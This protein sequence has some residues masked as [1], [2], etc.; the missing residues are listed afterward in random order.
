MAVLLRSLGYPA[1]VAVG[2]TPGTLQ[3]RELE[4][5]ERRRPRVGGGPVSDSGWLAFEPTPEQANP[6]AQPYLSPPNEDAPAETARAASGRASGARCS[7]R[8]GGS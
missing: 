5:H 7:E 8:T 2:F 4:R 6:I 1:R 3:R